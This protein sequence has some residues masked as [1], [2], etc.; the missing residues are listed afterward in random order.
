MAAL[1]SGRSVV[2]DA[3]TFLWSVGS[4]R[5]SA[6]P[7][8]CGSLLPVSSADAEIPLWLV[9]IASVKT[10]VKTLRNVKGE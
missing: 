9:N 8:G 1:G 10:A 2:P 7:L 4:H 3:L 5:A 6:G